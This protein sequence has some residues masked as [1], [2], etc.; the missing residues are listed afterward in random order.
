MFHL[1]LFHFSH[2]LSV[3]LSLSLCIYLR[4]SR[5]AEA[6]AAAHQRGRIRRPTDALPIAFARGRHRA[7]FTV[8]LGVGVAIV[9]QTLPRTEGTCMPLVLLFS[10]APATFH[11]DFSFIVLLFPLTLSVPLSL[12][13]S[14]SRGF[15]PLEPGGGVRNESRAGRR[16]TRRILRTLRDRAA[17]ILTFPKP[18]T[19]GIGLFRNSRQCAPTRSDCR[20]GHQ[21][22]T[23]RLKRYKRHHVR[24]FLSWIIYE[25]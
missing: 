22:L 13:L 1:C 18:H 23:H 17:V 15:S 9:C 4:L 16:R 10:F 21:Q 25:A 24:A 3:P 12:F 20:R 2:H 8:R 6:L 14:I 5:F 7:D 11:V 19:P